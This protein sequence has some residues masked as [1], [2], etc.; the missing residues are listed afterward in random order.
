MKVYL[1]IKNVKNMKILFQ[2]IQKKNMNLIN[3]KLKYICPLIMDS[4]PKNITFYYKH[5]NITSNDIFFHIE[6]ST[7]D[8]SIGMFYYIF[9]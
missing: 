6:Y 5:S 4:F 2:M 1:N 7:K 9:D 8:I 3:P